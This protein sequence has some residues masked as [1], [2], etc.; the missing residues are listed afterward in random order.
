MQAADT[1]QHAWY[2]YWLIEVLERRVGAGLIGFKGR[3]DAGGNVEF[4]YG[5]AEDFQ[6]HGYMSEAVQAMIRWA[7]AQPGCRRITAETLR[8][9]FASQR[10]LVKNGFRLNLQTQDTYE[11]EIK[12]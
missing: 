12:P 2:T 11:W 9:N 10:V 1:G 6:S 8:S 5:M 7:F 3:P 4:G